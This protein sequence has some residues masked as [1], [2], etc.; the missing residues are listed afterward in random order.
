MSPTH[1]LP[2]L[3]H[4]GLQSEV[5]WKIF[6]RRCDSRNLNLSPFCSLKTISSP[7]MLKPTLEATYEKITADTK[8][9][10]DLPSPM[11]KEYPLQSMASNEILPALTKVL[12]VDFTDCSFFSAGRSRIQC[13]RTRYCCAQHFL[14]RVNCVRWLFEN[15]K[16]KYPFSLQNLRD[17]RRWLGLTSY[18]TLEGLV[19]SALESAFSLL[20][21]SSTG[22]LSCSAE[23]SEFD[24]FVDLVRET[25]SIQWDYRL[26][27]VIESSK[28]FVITYLC[29]ITRCFLKTNI[30]NELSLFVPQGAPISPAKSSAIA[31]HK[32]SRQIPPPSPCT[33]LM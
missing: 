6:F 4:S 9:V 13:I 18:L 16:V 22:S 27:F 21:R 29:P 2:V 25:L 15:S 19:G 1:I 28:V 7:V 14:C 12:R 26:L 3:R 8:Y 32:G 17:Q 5:L 10:Q 11:R 24:R 30:W 31:S 33:P 23:T 20:P